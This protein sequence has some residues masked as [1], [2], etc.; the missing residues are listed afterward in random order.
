LQT[1]YCSDLNC[2]C[3]LSHVYS[4]IQIPLDLCFVTFQNVDDLHD[5]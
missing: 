3:S 4:I 5:V 1:I 2:G